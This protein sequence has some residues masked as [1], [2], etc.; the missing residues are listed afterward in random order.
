MKV[1]GLDVSSTTI[2][3]SIVSFQDGKFKLEHTEFF[4]PNKK[5]EDVFQTLFEVKEWIKSKIDEFKPDVVAVEDIAK[6]FAIGSSSANTVIVLAIYNRT[7][8]LG[9][10]EQTKKGPE[11]WNVRSARALVKPKGYEGELKKEDVPEVLAYLFQQ[12]FPYKYK[13]NGKIA[14]ESYDMSDSIV[15]ALAEAVK[16]SGEGK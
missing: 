6:H 14:D 10:Y 2:G 5:Y 15:I 3:L 16:L 8:G 1:M 7:I 4:K 9:I 13:K 11:L 12:P